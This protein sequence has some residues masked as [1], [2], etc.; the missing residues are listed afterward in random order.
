MSCFQSNS[1]GLHGVDVTMTSVCIRLPAL[2][3]RA[4]YKVN[5]WA[6]SGCKELEHIL[7]SG[8]LYQPDGFKHAGPQLYIPSTLTLKRQE[9]LGGA[10][11]KVSKYFWRKKNKKIKSKKTEKRLCWPATAA[12]LLHC[13]TFS[14]TTCT[15]QLQLLFTPTTLIA[16]GWFHKL[17][18]EA[19]IK[20]LNRFFSSFPMH[21]F[22]LDLVEKNYFF[23]QLFLYNKPV[24]LALTFKG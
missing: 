22:S 19:Q 10:A 9:G 11:R 17:P 12:A 4:S 3:T 23:P 14:K 18:N 8:D 24:G 1:V 7:P 13:G 15:A 20:N 5:F 21:Q 6:F 2:S 16:C